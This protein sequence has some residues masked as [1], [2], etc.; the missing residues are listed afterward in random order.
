MIVDCINNGK[1]DDAFEIDIERSGKGLFIESNIKNECNLPKMIVMEEN[2]EKVYMEL[3]KKQGGINLDDIKES[4][5]ENRRV[6]A[7]KAMY[8][9][10]VKGSGQC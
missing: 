3:S 4:V 5:V 6:L 10:K 1:N 7:V 2:G 9:K 8:R